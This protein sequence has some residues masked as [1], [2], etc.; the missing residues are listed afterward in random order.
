MA[1]TART[2]AI[3]AAAAELGFTSIGVTSAEPF[4]EAA[5]RFEAWVGRGAHGLMKYLERGADKRRDARAILPSAKSILSLALNYYTPTA[6]PPSGSFKI[7]RYAWGDDYHEVI[8]NK[9]EQLLLKI[10]EIEPEAEGRYYVDTGPL[11]EKAIAERAGIGWIG[12][13]TNV[14]TRTHGSWVFLAEII[15]SIELEYD[16]PASDMC[17]TCSRCIDAC[18]TDAIV[19][20]Y[21]LDATKCISYLTIEL[22]PEHSIP[23]AEALKLDG[24]VYGCDI[25]QDVCPWNRFSKETPISAFAPRTE[26]LELSLEDIRTMEQESFSKRFKKSAVKRTKVAG[27]QRTVRALLGEPSKQK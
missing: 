23:E 7:S 25:C 8:T 27:L 17:G 19:A 1:I 13:H 18:P 26:N 24:W 20:P 22:K 4:D 16:A 3:K 15:L 12:K 14:I 6:T 10:K 2:S 21:Q 11:L 9:L 5:D